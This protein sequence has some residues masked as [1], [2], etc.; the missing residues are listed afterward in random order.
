MGSIHVLRKEFCG[1]QQAQMTIY[2]IR[3]WDPVYFYVYVRQM[4]EFPLNCKKKK[5]RKKVEVRLM[6]NI[7]KSCSNFDEFHDYCQMNTFVLL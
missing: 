7:V 6:R 3:E 2:Y 5:K 4:C 1:H